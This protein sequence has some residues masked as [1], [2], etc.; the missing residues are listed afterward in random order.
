[1]V[2]IKIL[3]VLGTRPEIIKLSPLIPLF[4]EAFEHVLVHSGQHYAYKM[5]RIFFEELALRPPDHTLDVGSGSQADQTARIISSLEP[6]IIK[7]GPNLVLVQGDTNTTLSGA[8][9]AAKLGRKL[10][11]VEAGCRSFNLKMP[12]EVNRIVADHLADVLFAPDQP[13]HD[14]LLREGIDHTKIHLVGSTLTDACLRNRAYAN[15]STILSQLKLEPHKYLLVTIHRAENTDE[16]QTLQNIIRAIN[17]LSASHAVVFPVHPRTRKALEDAQ[18]GL[19]QNIMALEPVGYPDFLK[20]LESSTMV[21]TDSGG[22]Q[23]EAVAL[24]V[25]CAILRTETEWTKF[26]EAGRT[27]VVGTVA[28]AITGSVER[29]LRDPHELERM[30][31]APVSLPTGA[32]QRIVD[33]LR[34][35]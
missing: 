10:A 25:P 1:M 26:V 20:L 22:I 28:E 33:V 17:A 27:V 23:E 4:D 35:V 30:R 12:E 18:L 11:H 32:S 8:I 2:E 16:L 15:S 3:T 14:N 9:T 19:E 7:E 24:G 31:T 5:D 21:M 34:T 6:V 13:S 29:L